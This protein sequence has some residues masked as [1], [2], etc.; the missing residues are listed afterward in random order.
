MHKMSQRKEGRSRKSTHHI[1]RKAA[2][3]ICHAFDYAKFI[4]QPLNNFITINLDGGE[5]GEDA[6]A[7]FEIIRHKYRDWLNYAQKKLGG[8][9][10]PPA[11]AYAL[12][13]PDGHAHVHW[14]AHIPEHLQAEFLRKLP[15]WVGKAQG[16]VRPYDIDVQ[17]LDPETDKSVAKYMIKGTDPRYVE[18]LH[19]DHVA[20]QQGQVWGR[21]ATPSAAIGRAARKAAGFVP[22]RDRHKWRQLATKE[23]SQKPP[24]RSRRRSVVSKETGEAV[25]VVGPS[26]SVGA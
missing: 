13:C 18:Y 23:T 5:A 3:N 10:L 2:E 6:A 25:S 16:S 12:E 8:P 24:A 22:K 11:Y 21:R 1:G 9:V 20:E 4:G 17:R 26:V 19:L 15:T 14:A 7:I